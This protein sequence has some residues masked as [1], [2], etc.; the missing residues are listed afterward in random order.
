MLAVNIGRALK[1]R[2][3][4]KMASAEVR[5]VPGK[6]LKRPAPKSTGMPRSLLKSRTQMALIGQMTTRSLHKSTIQRQEMGNIFGRGGPG[7]QSSWVDPNA[8]PAGEFVSKYCLDLTKK[9]EEGKLDP[10]IGRDEEIRRTLQILSRRNK[11]NPLLIGDPGV[12]KTAIVEGL[13]LKI[14]SKDVPSNVAEMRIMALDMGQLVAGAKFRGEFEERFKGVLKDVEESNGKIILFIDELH[15]I[16]GAGAAEGSMDASNMIK[17]QLAR[18]QLRCIGATTTKEYRKYIEKDAALARR[19]QIVEIAE[20]TKE[21]AIAM[22]RGLKGPYETHHQLHI[23]DDALV[24]AVNMSDRYIRDRQLPDKAID[25]VDEAASK[26]KLQIYT[27]PE[28]LDKA[29]SKLESLKRQIAVISREEGRNVMQRKQALVAESEQLQLEVDEMSKQHEAEKSEMDAI[30]IM[31]H[32]INRLKAEFDAHLLAGKYEPAAKLEHEQL[33]PLQKEVVER[34]EKTEKFRFI[35]SQVTAQHI[36]DIVSHRTGI[37]LR[38]LVLSE[39]EK[40]LHME[41]YLT[42]RVV[43][44]PEACKAIADAVRISRAGLHSHERPLGSFFFMGPTGVGKTELCRAL[45]QTLFNSENALIRIDMSEFMEKYSIARLIGAP[46]GYIGHDEGGVLTEAVRRKPYAVVLFDEFEK[47]APEVSNILLQIL[48]AGRLTDGQGTTVDFKN[49]II[50]MTSNLGAQ[51]LAML[52]EGFPS[53]AAKNEVNAELRAHFQPEFLNRIDEVV[54]FNR[55]SREQMRPIVDI[56]LKQIA[57][58]HPL[59]VTEAA[60]DRLANLGYDPAYGARPMRRAINTYLL[61]PLSKL[62]LKGDLGEFDGVSVDVDPASE[63]DLQFS[64]LKDANRPAEDSTTG[65]L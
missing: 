56:Q 40:L 3:P 28:E 62:N 48:D 15:T 36:A 38:S 47:A 53:A 64:I 13:A 22:L 16:V 39:M 21:T 25:L 19:F 11:N 49:T 4:A 17:P 31:K 57:S 9:A 34:E 55:L 20:P 12:G 45:A 46:P 33:K 27:I 35:Q 2:I 43:G 61:R 1:G 7:Q 24:A 10:V 32:Q 14:A 30:A 42:Q 23:T 58:K 41:E 44:Q 5:Q 18:G 37:P 54:L 63:T 8:V 65:T 59:I 50:I 51:H 29:K 26:L 6:T 52:P 60:K